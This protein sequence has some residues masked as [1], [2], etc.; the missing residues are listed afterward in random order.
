MVRRRDS[1][2]HVD[3]AEHVMG[4]DDYHDHASGC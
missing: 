4:D 1:D 3:A 2:D